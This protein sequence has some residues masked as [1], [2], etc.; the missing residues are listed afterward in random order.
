[1]SP[2]PTE[3]ASFV[4][5]VILRTGG[6]VVV[7]VVVIEVAGEFGGVLVFET[8]LE[9]APGGIAQLLAALLGGI[10]IFRKTIEVD[11]AGGFEGNLFLVLVELF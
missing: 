2:F 6:A 4:P 9:T 10:Q 5:L 7:D 3:S 11:F 8:A 1:M